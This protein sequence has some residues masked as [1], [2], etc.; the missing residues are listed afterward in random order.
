VKAVRNDKSLE[1]TTKPVID[2]VFRERGR[3]VPLLTLNVIKK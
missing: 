3:P 1:K 2:K